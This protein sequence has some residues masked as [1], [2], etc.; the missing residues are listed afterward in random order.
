MARPRKSSGDKP[1]KKKAVSVKILEREH[2][3][4]TTTAY[5]LLDD[6]V[7]DH[8]DH[9]TD[10][11]IAIAWRF[12]WKPDV[13]GRL[14]LCGVKKGGDLDREMH[15]YDFVILLNHEAWNE[16]GFREEQMRALIDHA[17]CRCEV[18]KDSAGEPRIDENNRTVYRLRQPDVQEF[19]EIVARHGLWTTDLE[20]FAQTILNDKR[21]PLFKNQADESRDEPRP[22]LPLGVPASQI[23]KPAPKPTAAAESTAEDGE[24]PAATEKRGRGR[25][26]GPKKPAASMR[27]PLQRAAGH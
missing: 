5:K 2:A 21:R 11:K 22:T 26:K 6:L 12:G 23:K 8:H 17:L 25:P 20:R 7:E 18:S 13:D 24:P 4:R 1:Q 15:G 16:S 14:R 3:G 10:A 27:P 9:L 19:S